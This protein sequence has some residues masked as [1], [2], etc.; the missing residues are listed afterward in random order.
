M[1]I[2]QVPAYFNPTPRLSNYAK[3]HDGQAVTLLIIH[4]MAGTLPGTDAWF[5]NPKSQVST[6]FGVGTA[7]TGADEIHQYVSVN[8]SPY[9]AGGTP[10]HDGMSETN[11][12]SLQIE[13]Q[14]QDAQGNA[15]VTDNYYVL[16]SQL[17]NELSHVIFN[18]RPD[19]SWIRKHSEVNPAKPECPA[20]IDIDRLV[21]MAQALWDSGAEPTAVL[22]SAP[23]PPKTVVVPVSVVSDFSITINAPLGAGRFRSDSKTGA[24]VMVTYP[25]GTVVECVETVIGDSVTLEEKDG[26]SRTSNKWYK[27]KIHG[28]YISATVADVNQPNPSNQQA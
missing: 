16:T 4:G 15:H 7:P 12:D 2:K 6:H 3:G 5:Q 20:N 22:A 24:S 21:E 26:S 28:W 19:R 14:N 11:W 1:N 27:S 25:N 9:G 10:I 17:I 8:D 13:I 23:V 18:R